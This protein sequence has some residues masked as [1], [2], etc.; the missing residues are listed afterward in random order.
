MSFNHNW[1][2]TFIFAATD[3]TTS[4]LSRI[5]HLLSE[6]Q[7]VQSRL[8]EEVTTARQAYGDLDYDT[9]QALPFLDAVC[10]ETLRLFSPVSYLSRV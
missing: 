5:F 4:A 3:T 8:R 1:D 6:H 7:D 2:S 9:L 10:R